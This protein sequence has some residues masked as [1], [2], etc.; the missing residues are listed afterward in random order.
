MKKIG[1]SLFLSACLV[2]LVHVMFN[3]P[4]VQLPWLG[5]QGLTPDSKPPLEVMPFI[6]MFAAWCLYVFFFQW[7]Y[8]KLQ[9]KTLKDAIILT[10]LLWFFVSF[11]VT[12]VHYIFL[13][14]PLALILLDGLSMVT[15]KMTAGIVMWAV[16]L[17]PKKAD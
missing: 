13:R 9:F 12:S 2:L 7:L 15:A 4:I 5:A 1:I 10:L 17:Q 14:F 6:M 8:V 11:P 3:T 16:L